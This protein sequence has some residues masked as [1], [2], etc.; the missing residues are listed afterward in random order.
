MPRF[1]VTLPKKGRAFL[2]AGG[3]SRIRRLLAYHYGM[4][5]GFWQ[6]KR[7]ESLGDPLA[8]FLQNR[9]TY[10]YKSVK[11]LFLEKY[12]EIVAS[13]GEFVSQI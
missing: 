11:V 2:Y 5:R 12:I 10:F 1:V 9:N 4:E 13:N 8:H 7:A 6:M 3:P